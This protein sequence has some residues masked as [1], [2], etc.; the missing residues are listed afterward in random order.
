MSDMQPI[1]AMSA[2]PVV[3]NGV[4]ASAGGRVPDSARAPGRTEA[5][6]P[7]GEAVRFLV[8]TDDFQFIRRVAALLPEGA[9][10]Q[11]LPA[12]VRVDRAAPPTGRSAAGGL[13]ALTG[14]QQDVAALLVQGLS[15]KAIA[16]ELGL[17]HFTVRN[18]VSQ[19][20]RMLGTPTRRGAVKR[21]APYYDGFISPE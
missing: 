8:E 14:R 2:T 12:A 7:A 15:N 9:K 3:R 17:S 5:G 1:S 4:A 11:I 16:R 19:L 20:L 18:H 21:L 13:P 10:L 6:L